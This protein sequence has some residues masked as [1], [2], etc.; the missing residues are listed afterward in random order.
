MVSDANS[1]KRRAESGIF[2]V[3]REQEAALRRFLRRISPASS[4][5]DDIAQETILRALQ[6]E[7]ERDILQPKAYLYMIARNV[8]RDAM[9]K[10]S[11]SLID[12]IEDFAP[13][14]VSSNEPLVEDQVDGRQRMLLF[15]EAV[16]SLPQQCQQ[17]FVLKKVYGYSHVEISR[18][19]GISV[20][21]T[22]KHVAAGLKRCV[23]F[24]DRRLAVSGT[25][26]EFRRSARTG[27]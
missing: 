9:D 14:S 4:D 2:S 1:Q 7:R 3:F 8:V 10:K 12:Y 5:I 16:A 19:L 25:G 13:E 27:D 23:D 24:L 11:R 6:A 20:S 21:T 22:E 17:V 18:Q 15:W 26:E